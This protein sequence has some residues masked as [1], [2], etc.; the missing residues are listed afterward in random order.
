MRRLETSG[1]VD[2]EVW[3]TDEPTR[4]EPGEPLEA[5][6]RTVVLG[7]HLARLPESKHDAFVRAVATGLREPVIDYVRLNIVA[8]RSAPQGRG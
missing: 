3:L 1:F 4:F 5:Y 6:L 2:P 7:S 8:R